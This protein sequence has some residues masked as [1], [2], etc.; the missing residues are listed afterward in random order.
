MHRG[1]T[2]KWALREGVLWAQR[3]GQ[4]LPAV[5]M[6]CRAVTK[7]CWLG[8]SSAEQPAREASSGQRHVVL[9]RATH[10]MARQRPGHGEVALEKVTWVGKLAGICFWRSNGV[11]RAGQGESSPGNRAGR[12]Q[13]PERQSSRSLWESRRCQA[14]ITLQS[15]PTWRDLEGFW[16]VG[17]RSTFSGS[18]RKCPVRN[19]D[20][21]AASVQQHPQAQQCPVLLLGGEN[22][23]RKTRGTS[24][25]M[26]RKRERPA[27]DARC[28]PLNPFS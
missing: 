7:H 4:A 15:F 14:S 3:A 9:P 28:P 16:N 12:V 2:P 20:S 8:L 11:G 10:V 17:S 25:S 1:H 5:R 22:P 27:G 26:E 6:P 18:V 21:P 23:A 24:A 13:C 19:R